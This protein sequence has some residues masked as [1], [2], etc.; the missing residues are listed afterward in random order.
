MGR[1][2]LYL[3][4]QRW[5]RAEQTALCNLAP[6]LR[7]ITCPLIEIC[8]PGFSN[9]SRRTAVAEQLLTETADRVNECCR[10][11]STFVDLIHL[12]QNR[13][14]LRCR[15][16]VH[17]LEFLFSA[18]RHRGFLFVDHSPS[19]VPVTGLHR[20]EAFQNAV[21]T[22]VV[23]GN[24]RL[25][26]RL[27][28][29]EIQDQQVGIQLLEL[30]RK[31][32]L[33][34][35][36]VDLIVD[37]KSVPRTGLPIEFLMQNVPN[38]SRWR[39]LTIL[40]GAFPKDLQEIREVGRHDLGRNDWFYFREYVSGSGLDRIASFG[41]YTIQHPVYSEPPENCNPSASIRYAT[42]D[43]WIIMRGEGIRNPDGPG[44]KQ[45]RAQAQVLTSFDE[46]HGPEFSFGCRYIA[47]ATLPSNGLG[48][49]ESWLAATINQHMT[50]SALQAMTVL[51]RH[52]PADEREPHIETP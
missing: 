19:V 49:P 8:P 16:G 12:E 1:P 14:R 2:F 38:I 3:P 21:Q 24:H 47:E 25:C 10:G 28:R 18:I 29:D 46:F 31:F 40:V 50:V 45:W 42:D 48:N 4:V 27:T 52:R 23:N 32:Q 26:I 22:V 17:P 7:R 9:D 34:P 43:T 30:L 15:N 20:S 36:D 39:S 33:E 11:Y 13:P 44:A 5:K 41:D 37:L 6:N 35:T 51:E